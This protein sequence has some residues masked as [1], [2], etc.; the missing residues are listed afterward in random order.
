MTA[1][2]TNCT[3][4]EELKKEYHKLAIKFH[5]DNNIGNQEWATEE[6]KKVSEAFTK[7]FDRLK[8]FHV[9]A[10]GE[11]YEKATSE[12]A[13][14]FMTII[15]QLLNYPDMLIEVCGSWIWV[16]GNTK[17]H[18]DILKA[19]KFKYSPNKE[20]WYKA[21]EGYHKQNRKPYDMAQIRLTY[22]SETYRRKGTELEDDRKRA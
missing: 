16:S 4:A 9:N 21:P 6:M 18:K 1:Y 15:E 17:E 3:T 11:K 10:K 12:T 20:V 8:A 22:G 7:A 2:F 13:D 14:E 5:P 19:L